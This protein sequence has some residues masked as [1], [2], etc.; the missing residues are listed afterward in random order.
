MAHILI[1]YLWTGLEL[2]T[3][4]N[5]LCYAVPNISNLCL[6]ALLWVLDTNLFSG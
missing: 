4:L 1:C 5:I 3:G 6:L 2:A